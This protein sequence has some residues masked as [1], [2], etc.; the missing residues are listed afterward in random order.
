MTANYCDVSHASAVPRTLRPHIALGVAL[1]ALVAGGCSAATGTHRTTAPQSSP[2]SSS[3]RPAPAVTG[4]TSATQRPAAPTGVFTFAFAGD[5][6]FAERTAQRLAHPETAFGQAAAV[7]RGA[8]LTMVNLETAITTRGDPAPKD[9][10]FRAPA[11]AFVALRDAGVDVATMANNHAADYGGVGL[12]DSLAA[13]RATH[14]PVVGIGADATAAFAPWTVAVHG[15]KVAVFAASQ[16]RD[17]TLANYSAGPAS[18]GIASAYDARLVRAVR[19]AKAAGYV[20]IVYLH[21]GTEYTDC[22]NDDQ[23]G[24][25]DTLARAGAAAVIGTHVH[26][27]QGAGW[28]ADGSYVAYGLGNYLWWR[29][30]G[31][32]QDDNGVLTLTFRHGRVASAR[33]APAHLDNRGVPVPASGAEAARIAGQWARVRQC[34][35]L[36]ATPPH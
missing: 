14:F 5:V 9:F 25:A 17:E 26:E 2:G 36:A 34:A 4:R 18:P 16:V 35:G 23:R 29:S 30:F 11:T 20:V 15:A 33:F 12:H 7:L 32:V 24:L 8:D 21:W 1:L 3:A 19:S 6:H 13:I 22:P 28:R 27:L 31:N 10:H